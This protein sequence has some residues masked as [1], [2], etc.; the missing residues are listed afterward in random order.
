MSTADL[1]STD[2]LEALAAALAAFAGAAVEAL[3]QADAAAHHE[4]EALDERER[5]LEWEASSLSDEYDG[6][7][8]EEDGDHLLDRLRDVNEEMAGV[9]AAAACL[10]DAH[11]SF[12]AGAREL[13]RIADAH[14]P[15]A[16]EFL[17][18]KIAQVHAYVS[19]APPGAPG[20]SGDATGAG[21]TLSR[22]DAPASPPAIPGGFTWVP[23]EQVEAT[24][25]APSDFRK[26]SQEEMEH[27]F[28]MLFGE[29]LPRMRGGP[30]DAGMFDDLDRDAGRDAANG[31]RRVYDAFFG[32]D[33]IRLERRAGD[34]AFSITDGRHRIATAR[35]L[36]LTHVPARAVEVG[37]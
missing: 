16:R 18:R 9:A 27:G 14:L 15:V 12:A 26:V 11:A 1:R 10:Q 34:C 21:H 5:D 13:R 7:D 6:L 25:L 30:I 35:R 31:A 2:A 24:V 33:A 3:D 23:L 37:G 20:A 8:E 36:G 29:V 28:A 19:L 17:G 32:I 22:P 4:L